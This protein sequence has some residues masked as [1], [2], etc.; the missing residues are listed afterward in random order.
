MKS[1][2]F[3]FFKNKIVALLGIWF[4]KV[5]RLPVGTH[6]YY[7][8]KY[9]IKFDFNVIFDIGS[10]IGDTAALYHHHFPKSQLHC[11]EPFSSTFKKLTGN[12]KGKDGLHFYQLAFGDKNEELIVPVKSDDL[13][14]VNTLKTE[15]IASPESMNKETLKV[16][17][18]DKFLEEHTNIKAID[19]LKIDTEGFDLKVLS[20]A[21]Q[22]LSN[23]S[24][25]MILTEVGFSKENKLH[26]HVCEMISFLEKYDYT[27]LGIFGMD[28]NNLH[29]RPQFG[30]VLFIHKSL[31]SKVV[32]A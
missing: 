30:N 4:Y 31:V 1:K 23:L 13:A 24:V 8:L 5:N 14:N 16:Q 19:L 7:F 26:V 15:T 18:L 12:L 17:T 29:K 11:F 10:N 21:H 28:V 27:F 6:V 22:A 20:G 32:N 2:L 9:R 25:K 3:F